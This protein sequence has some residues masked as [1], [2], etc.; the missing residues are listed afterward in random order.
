MFGS[1]DPQS[2]LEPSEQTTARRPENPEF[3]GGKYEPVVSA[4]EG[5]MA[6]VW[7]GYTHGEAGF[8]RKVAIKRVHRHLAGDDKFANMFVEEAHIVAELNHPNIVQ[9]HDFGQDSEGGFY[10]VMEW[11]S[12]LNLKDYVRGYA[13]V[14]RTPPWPIVSAIAIEVLRA[15]SAAHSRTDVSGRPVPIIH[16]D[17]T[18]ANIMVGFNGYVKLTDFGL[19]RAL[20]RPRTTDPGIVKGKVSYLAPELF[21]H[22]RPNVRCDIFSVGVTVWEALSGRRLFDGATDVEAAMRVIAC[23]VPDLREIRPEIPAEL[24]AIVHRSLAKDPNERFQTAREMIAA[25]SGLLCHPE[26]A[27][28]GPAIA[29]SAREAGDF[30]L[31]HE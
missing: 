21:E 27:T 9:I 26:V 12:G 30:L 4:G 31:E 25:L 20:D 28:D 14:G 29:Q 8:R 3:L 16:R 17:V 5:G 2:E 13:L 22:H 19:S 6:S 7:M 15:L 11:V 18:P 10:I 1:N 23:E 24:S